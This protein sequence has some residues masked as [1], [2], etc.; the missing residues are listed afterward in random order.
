MLPILHEY[1]IILI[2]LTGYIL[3]AHLALH[4]LHD[5]SKGQI[6]T[7]FRNTTMLVVAHP[8]DETMFFGPTILNVLENDKPLV[9]LC[10]TNGDSEGQGSLREQ[11]LK[12]VADSL[13]SLV[14]LR[15]VRESVLRDG[16]DESWPVEDIVLHIESHIRDCNCSI[17]TI[18]TFDSHGISGHANH[19]STFLAVEKMSRKSEGRHM[20]YL[21]LQSVPVW[22]KF[23]SFLDSVLT[24]S[25][26]NGFLKTT[27]RES[28]TLAIEMSSYPRLTRILRMHKTQ[29]LWFRQFYMVFSRYMFINDFVLL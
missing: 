25:Y 18:V 7:H 22:R 9:I 10:L 8:D 21:S 17:G 23:T 14:K 16:M 19:H 13:G 26:T 11:E 5:Q 20:N 29:M 27:H 24:I 1:K 12:N 4:Q 6:L 15:L 28:I 3:I 2:L